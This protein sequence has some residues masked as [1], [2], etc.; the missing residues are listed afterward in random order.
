MSYPIERWSIVKVTV[1]VY[2][3]M[4]QIGKPGQVFGIGGAGDRS[5]GNDHNTLLVL[6]VF[7]VP[8]EHID[9]YAN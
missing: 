1:D 7:F 3:E 8:S 6:G 5:A 2:F 4:D 9:R